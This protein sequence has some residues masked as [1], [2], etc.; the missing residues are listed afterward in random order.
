M[1][2]RFKQKLHVSSLY[3]YTN[4]VLKS[5]STLYNSWWAMEWC[6]C[7]HASSHHETVCCWQHHLLVAYTFSSKNTTLLHVHCAKNRL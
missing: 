4:N 3:T 1:S 7:G 6:C 2:N 5:E